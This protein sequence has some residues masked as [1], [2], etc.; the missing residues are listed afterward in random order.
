M[1]STKTKDLKVD[2]DDDD[3]DDDDVM[4]DFVMEFMHSGDDKQISLGNI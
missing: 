1:L 2:G 4:F 3:D